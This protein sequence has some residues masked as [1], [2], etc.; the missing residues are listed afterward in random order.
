MEQIVEDTLQK[1]KT[2]CN[3]CAKFSV[4]SGI[5]NWWRLLWNLNDTK[6]LELNGADYTL[7]LVFMRYAFWFFLAVSSFGMMVMAP[8]YAVGDPIPFS[9]ETNNTS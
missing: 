7:Y 1:K 5:F 4:T 3:C 8:I 9:S 2:C 6:L